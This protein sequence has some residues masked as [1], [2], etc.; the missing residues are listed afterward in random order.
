MNSSDMDSLSTVDHYNQL[1]PWTTIQICV[2]AVLSV[3]GILGNALTILA[4]FTTRKLQSEPNYLI[5]NLAVADIIVCLVLEP[6]YGVI[7]L[8]AEWIVTDA[9]CQAI[10]TVT[11]TVMGASVLTFVAIAINKCINIE[12]VRPTNQGLPAQ[13]MGKQIYIVCVVI[14]TL[15]LLFSLLF[16]FN[17]VEF[18]E[19]AY[20]PT[21]R[22]CTIVS[23][24]GTRLLQ[25]NMTCL[26]V[27]YT[28]VIFSYI[29]I[30]TVVHKNSMRISSFSS[31][32]Q[33]NNNNNK[34]I[35]RCQH[36]KNTKT[37]VLI[38][39]SIPFILFSICLLPSVILTSSTTRS[40]SSVL[41]PI[42]VLAT[43]LAF[44][45]SSVNILIYACRN[46][47]YRHAYYNILTR[48]VTKREIDVI[49]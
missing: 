25:F 43:F 37:K 19:L 29:K 47:A 36:A 10:A 16:L 49:V 14:W 48:Q 20:N 9:A 12:K 18:G 5:V 7:I 6:I 13:R 41:Q 40:T 39:V 34:T 23:L 42:G 32:L 27:C 17:I 1:L 44:A 31:K 2:L 15:P 30:Y 21:T 3:T 46:K 4:V 38:N 33:Y 24:S 26:G 22:T 35:F 11:L 28:F 45:N 8:N